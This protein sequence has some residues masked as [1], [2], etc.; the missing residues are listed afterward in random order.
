M[1]INENKR[2]KF[3]RNRTDTLIPKLLYKVDKTQDVMVLIA[4]ISGAMA[5][6]CQNVFIASL[7]VNLWLSLKK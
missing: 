6:N 3:R 7:V 1:L 5:Q 2:K 4:F